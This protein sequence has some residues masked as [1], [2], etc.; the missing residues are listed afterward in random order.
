MCV[1]LKPSESERWEKSQ[2]GMN[3]F[4]MPRGFQDSIVDRAGI[5]SRSWDAVRFC[6][7]WL[8]ETNQDFAQL[9]RKATKETPEIRKLEKQASVS[10]LQEEKWS[11]PEGV[12]WIDNNP[13]PR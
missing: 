8:A 6:L 1:G 5:N 10:F 2:K 3:L 7:G 13:Y 4:S 12:R 9:I 11:P